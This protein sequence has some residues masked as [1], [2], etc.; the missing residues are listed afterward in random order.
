MEPFEWGKG[1]TQQMPVDGPDPN[2]ESPDPHVG[3]VAGKVGLLVRQEAIHPF[4]KGGV[5][6]EGKYT[7]CSS[8]I[9]KACREKEAAEL[10][11]VLGE[12]TPSTENKGMSPRTVLKLDS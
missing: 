1:D 3:Q 2:S 11:K 5:R 6:H 4:C 7:F 8:M 9:C 10:A 12:T